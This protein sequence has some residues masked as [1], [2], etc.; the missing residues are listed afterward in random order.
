MTYYVCNIRKI[1]RRSR[2]RRSQNAA[3]YLRQIEELESQRSSLENNLPTANI[4]YL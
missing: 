3:Q 2:R 4:E 1:D